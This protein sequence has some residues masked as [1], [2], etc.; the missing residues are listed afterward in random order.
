MPILFCNTAWM[1]HY[2]GRHPDDPPSGGGG[3][4]S[5]NGW[6]GEECNFVQGEDGQLYGHFETIKKNVDRQVDIS[7][8]GALRRDSFIDGVDVVWTAPREGN[9]PRVVV[10]WWRS[11]RVYRRRQ[12]FNG[13]FPSARHSRDDIESYMVKAIASDAVFLPANQ[14]HMEMKRGVGW[15]GQVSWWY[16]DETANKA[17]QKFV[18][19]VKAAME[20]AAPTVKDAGEGNQRHGRRGPAGAAAAEDYRRYVTAFEGVVHARHHPLQSRFKA[21]LDSLAKGVIY[22]RCFR[23]DLRYVL[24]GQCEVMVEIKPTEPKTLRLAIR[25]AIG[26]LLDYRQ[27]QGWTGRQLIL[28]ETPVTNADDRSL[29][30]E[31]GFGLA[32]PEAEHRFKIVWPP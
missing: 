1:K 2:A 10:G 8:L 31:N 5:M 11:A 22:P 7:R 3:F 26:Q 21:Y 30:F 4:V 28:V 18:S 25:T 32:W 29:A 9:A 27:Q 20:G 6:A 17:A 19:L 23:D 13:Q 14:R 16:A 15:S 12:H 24:A